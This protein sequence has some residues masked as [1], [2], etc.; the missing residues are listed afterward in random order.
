MTE[1][2]FTPPATDAIINPYGDRLVAASHLFGSDI[3]SQRADDLDLAALAAVRAI[4]RT[5]SPRVLDLACGVG[6]QALRFADLGVDVVASDIL[7]KPDLQEFLASHRIDFRPGDMTALNTWLQSDDRF[8]VFYCQR[9]LHYLRYGA[10]SEVLRNLCNYAHPG[11][12][13][14]VSFS[15][16]NSELGDGYEPRFMPPM[17]R[18]A[19]LEPSMAEKHGILQPVCLYRLI[20]ARE[21]LMSSGWKPVNAWESSFGNIKI[22]AKKLSF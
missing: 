11:A 17:H 1:A 4:Q 6:G 13:L 20:E 12:E 22:A 2:L 19:K 3:A 16:L 5:T 18:F 14:F 8:H 7:S 10:A 15:G 9:T 21:L